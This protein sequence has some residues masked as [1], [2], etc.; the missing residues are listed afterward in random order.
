MLF[1][2]WQSLG[3]LTEEITAEQIAALVQSTSFGLMI[4]FVSTGSAD[5]VSAAA[6][7]SRM[8]APRTGDGA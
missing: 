5:V 6:A 8:L 7:L 2:S 4:E 3:L 1:R